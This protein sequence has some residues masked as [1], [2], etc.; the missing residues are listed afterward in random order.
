MGRRKRKNKLMAVIRK[1][2]KI[3]RDKKRLK[4]VAKGKTAGQLLAE[5]MAAK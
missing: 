5:K 4:R 2:A 1:F 3:N